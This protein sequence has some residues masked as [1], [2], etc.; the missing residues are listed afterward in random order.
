MGL[1]ILNI[2]LSRQ[3][4]LRFGLG[5]TLAIIMV[6]ALLV[7]Q[8]RKNPTADTQSDVIPPVQNLK[9]YVVCLKDSQS[10]QWRPFLTK[11]LAANDNCL[12]QLDLWVTADSPAGHEDSDLD[13][14]INLR[15]SP[16][17]DQNDPLFD[18]RFWHLATIG[19]GGQEFD[20]E[21][22]MSWLS[23]DRILYLHRDL[24]I[25]E[26]LDEDGAIYTI[27]VIAFNEHS[28]SEPVTYEVKFPL[29]N[30]QTAPL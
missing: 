10:N 3:K 4:L 30:I 25:D 2:Q 1:M 26:V 19:S 12:G 7:V 29:G 21:G 16:T 22:N 18:D 23:T 24:P 28:Q 17:T 6:S 27:E 14:E 11:V 20:N 9:A 13:Y 5:S 8:L 15:Y